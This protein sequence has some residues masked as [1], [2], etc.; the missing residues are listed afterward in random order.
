MVD[1]DSISG[2]IETAGDRDWLIVNLSANQNYRFY[3][4]SLSVGEGTREDPFRSDVDPY[5]YG[6]FDDL[7]GSPFAGTVVDNTH[8]RNAMVHFTP[9]EGYLFYPCGCGL[10][11]RELYVGG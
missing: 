8:S 4:R 5:L 11:Y 6:I 10:W 9:A 7:N 1:G 2:S 3:L